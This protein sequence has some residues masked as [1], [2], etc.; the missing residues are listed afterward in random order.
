MKF[1]LINGS[2]RKKF[3]TAQ[4]LDAVAEGITDEIEKQEKQAKVE[5]IDLYNINYIY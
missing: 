5:I 1:Y 4:L 2:N 3:N